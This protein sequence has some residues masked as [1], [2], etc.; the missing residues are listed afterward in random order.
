MVPFD[1]HHRHEDTDQLIKMKILRSED[2]V[3]CDVHHAITHRRTHK[4]TDRRNRDDRT[5]GSG[6]G[7]N[8]RVQEVDRVVTHPHREVE[9]R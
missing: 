5:K 1:R 7:T 2:T 4:H 6:L 3:P 9:N 8:R